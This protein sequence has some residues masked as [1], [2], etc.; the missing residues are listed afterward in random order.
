M[1]A[2]DLAS[3]EPTPGKRFNDRRGS[4]LTLDRLYAT[5]DTR[6]GPLTVFANDE[7]AIGQSLRKYGEWAE[8]ELGFMRSLIDE[9][10]TVVD[11]GAYIG[12]HALAFSHFVGPSGR[13]IAIEPQ[14]P[15]FELL[16]RNIKLNALKN[17][18]AENAAVSIESG[19]ALI[20]VI[21]IERQESFGSASLVSSLARS[22]PRSERQ[23]DAGELATRVISIDE[24][25][26]PECSL[27]KID[28][29]GVEDLVLRGATN[30]IRRTS[31]I[32]YAECNSLERG[33][34]SLDVLRSLGYRVRAH[35]VAAYNEANFTGDKQNI[36]GAAREVAL[37]GA[38][39]ERFERV[40]RRKPRPYE[41]LLDIETVDDLSLAML[42]KPQYWPEALASGA[43]ARSAKLAG[44]DNIAA[45]GLF[46]LREELDQT[47]RLTKSL[48]RELDELRGNFERTDRAL[49]ECQE[50]AVSRFHALSELQQRFERNVAAARENLEAIESLKKEH[51]ALTAKFSAQAVEKQNL[52]LERD[53]QMMRADAAE[54]A[55]ASIR[56]SWTWR[57]LRIFRMIPGASSPARGGDRIRAGQT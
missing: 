6:Y 48:Y 37:V 41:M 9:G 14:P 26:L 25:D 8:N 51:A 32:V 4:S 21:N 34:R 42:N 11:V 50:L 55:L 13:V 1:Q 43:A 36:F 20:P 12:T 52:K 54:A 22:E 53:N 47:Q 10:A 7:G 44:S 39:P 56:R 2:N 19:E 17:I 16:T 49:A 24:L 18:A 30:T 23:S 46:E 29:E 15:S 33:V 28:A 5:L 3:F 31:P 57:F 35:V 38:S 45:V 27:I 40:L